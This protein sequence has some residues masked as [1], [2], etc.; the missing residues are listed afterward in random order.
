MTESEL[1]V[2]VQKILERRG[3]LIEIRS[4]LADF[5][6]SGG[7]REAADVTLREILEQ[8][9]DDA[10][11]GLVRDALDVVWGWCS[12]TLWIWPRA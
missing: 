2:T 7:K 6:S 4:A 9:V 11:D 10:A 1:K 5:A 3:T 12:P 8:A